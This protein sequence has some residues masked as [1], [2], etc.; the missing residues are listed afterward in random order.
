[1]LLLLPEF[2]QLGKHIA[3]GLGFVQNI[4]LW[5][6]AG[7]FDTASQSKPLLHLWSLGIEEQF[8]LAFPLLLWL[9]CRMHARGASVAVLAVTVVSFALNI[10]YVKSDPSGVY[11]LPQYRFWELTAGAGVALVGQRPLPRIVRTVV[12]GSG[13]ALL[14]VA[15]FAFTG[16]TAFPGWAAAVPVV[17]TALLIVAGADGWVNRT[18]LAHPIAVGIGLISY[19]LYLW[20]WPILT[21]LRIVMM[22][23]PPTVIRGAAVVA[24]I[25]LAWAT[26]AWIEHPIRTG[27]RARLK[28]SGLTAAAATVGIVGLVTFQDKGIPVRFAPG[29]REVASYTFDPTAMY[30]MGDCYYAGRGGHVFTPT[31]FS[32][33]C[34][35]FDQGASA[36][37]LWGDSF[38]A[39]MYA[40]IRDAFPDRRILQYSASL[41]PPILNVDEEGLGSCP[42]INDFVF[43]GVRA[44]PPD[45]VLLVSN[46][47]Q[48]EWRH[49]ARTIAGLRDAG[50]R[51]IVIVGSLPSWNRPL[52]EL[53]AR[54][55]MKSTPPIAPVRMV[56]ASMT[57]QFRFDDELERFAIDQNVDYVSPLHLLCSERDGCIVRDPSG[58][59]PLTPLAFDNA[60]LTDIGSRYLGR[61]LREH[62]TVRGNP[63]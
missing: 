38:S 5:S 28:V 52:P 29:L 2:S 46:W 41:C 22:A 50:V 43:R 61:L 8:Y 42:A 58:P 26:Y 53:I 7:Y 19:P 13:L 37:L 18:L 45:E 36:M 20:H 12:G 56:D 62:R 3:G 48:H 60:H 24:S 30:R 17:G 4:V 39:A 49:T 33:T 63:L 9:A 31:D 34:G 32:P 57:A 11:F 55:V 10:V 6:E 35:S 51:H 25:L 14:V 59:S 16:A 40:G 27:G 1:M 23:E 15:V 47:R 44:H 21:L 54:R